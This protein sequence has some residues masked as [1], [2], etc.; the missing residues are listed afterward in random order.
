MD[1]DHVYNF[2]ACTLLYSEAMWDKLLES[3]YD[4][5]IYIPM[6]SGLEQLFPN[7]LYAL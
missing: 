6:S 2:T 7:C 3:K 5:I 1:P 4:D